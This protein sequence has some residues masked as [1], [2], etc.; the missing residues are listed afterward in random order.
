MNNQYTRYFTFIKPIARNRTV[1]TYGTLTFNLFAIA[2]FVI[3][4]I[5]PTIATIIS[6]KKGISDQQKVLT[7][8]ETKEQSLA[9]GK[10][11]LSKID[12][13]TKAKLD[14]LLPDKTSVSTLTNALSNSS[15]G[16][17]ASIS[18]LQLQPTQLVG[19]PAKLIKT[20]TI[21]DIDFTLNLTGN[22]DNLLSAL[23]SLNTLQRL[24]S[25]D[26]ISFNQPQDGVLIMSINAKAFFLQ[27]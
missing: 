17:Q 2:I 4:A 27:N 22:Y 25:I 19:S 24:V 12:S 26:S 20:P 8:L 23:N 21:K 9:L 13:S 10:Q 11:N 16:N 14:T 3:F 1:R 15:L 18:G 6:L 5:Q 7:Q